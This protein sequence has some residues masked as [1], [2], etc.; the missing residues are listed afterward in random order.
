MTNSC[1]VVDSPQQLRNCES[2]NP[3][4]HRF[5]VNGSYPLPK[6]LQVAVVYQNLPGPNDD[7]NLV[8]PTADIA[9]SLGR[10]LAGHTRNVTIGLFVPNSQFIDDR[11]N[12]LDVRVSKITNIG[13]AKLQANFDLYNVF[14]N[15]A[16]L[17]VNSAYGPQWL[18]PTQMLDARLAKVSFQVDF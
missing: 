9:P 12:Q 7:A 13:F 10:P 11:T 3:F 16:V 6:G 18:R 2:G 4:Q 8:V 5:K 1:F 17:N 15:T 14:N